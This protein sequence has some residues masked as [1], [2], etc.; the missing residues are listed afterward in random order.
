MLSALFRKT[1][2][3]VSRSSA[4]LKDRSSQAT[5]YF[6]NGVGLIELL[7]VLLLV[8]FM[9]YLWKNG[10]TGTSSSHRLSEQLGTKQRLETQVKYIQQMAQDR[11]R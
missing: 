2:I 4:V 11:Y 8:F 9:F 5:N 6:K 1:K 7:A 3:F 10:S